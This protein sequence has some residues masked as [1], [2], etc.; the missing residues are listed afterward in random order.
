MNH[1]DI[2]TK[3]ATS[4]LRI[5]RKNGV[6]GIYNTTYGNIEISFE[7]GVYTVCNFNNTAIVYA[8]GKKSAVI[9]FVKSLYVI[10]G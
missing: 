10:E 9:E 8:V 4:D 7:N 6:M 3:V 2:R 5:A 1:N